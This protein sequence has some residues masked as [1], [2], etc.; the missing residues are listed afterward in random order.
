MKVVLN[1]SGGFEVRK[2]VTFDKPGEY[3]IGRIDEC[4]CPVHDPRI[5]KRHCAIVLEDGGASVKDLG[6]TN[7]TLADG[8]LLGG[9]DGSN[10]NETVMDPPAAARGKQTGPPPLQAPLRDGSRIEMGSTK[11]VVSLIADDG[12]RARLSEWVDQAHDKVQEAIDLFRLALQVDPQ[13]GRL[14]ERIMTLES[15]LQRW[16]PTKVE[17]RQS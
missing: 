13:N 15:N 3:S 11:I 6:S 7:G 1:L 9:D 16:A 10:P 4:D 8:V 12:D 5:S 2:S 14:I 17:R